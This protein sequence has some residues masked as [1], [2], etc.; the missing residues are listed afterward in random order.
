MKKLV[1]DPPLSEQSPSDAPQHP[2]TSSIKTAHAHFGTCNGAHVPLFAVCAGASIEDA[3][4][5]LAMTLKAAFETNAQACEMVD[6]RFAGLLWATQHSLE[7]SE[8][9]VESLLRGIKGQADPM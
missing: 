3:L 5:H 7:I 6:R 9:V 2:A 1:P 4:V 8:A